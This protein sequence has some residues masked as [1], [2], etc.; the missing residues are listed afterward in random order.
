M[1]SPA[2][3]QILAGC[4]GRL[5]GAA[6]WH[7]AGRYPPTVLILFQVLSTPHLP[8]HLPGVHL[9]HRWGLQLSSVLQPLTHRQFPAPRP[10]ALDKA[11]LYCGAYYLYL[12]CY[13]ALFLEY[14]F[15]TCNKEDLQHS[16]QALTALS[17]STSETPTAHTAALCEALSPLRV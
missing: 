8:Q 9:G 11:R 16:L 3:Y 13:G 1:R 4:V 2:A 15:M 6:Q 10:E 17:P 7:Q 5:W 14:H 12:C